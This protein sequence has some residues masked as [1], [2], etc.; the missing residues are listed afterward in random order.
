[1]SPSRA[2]H[3]SDSRS[4]TLLLHTPENIRHSMRDPASRQPQDIGRP[5]L[6]DIPP[7]FATVDQ[8]KHLSISDITGTTVEDL[9]PIE[10]GEVAFQ[11]SGEQCAKTFRLTLLYVNSLKADLALAAEQGKKIDCLARLSQILQSADDR[12]KQ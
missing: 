12:M 6:P 8:E 9:F 5:H 11:L 2:A 3:Y 1:M 4:S 10:H 7:A